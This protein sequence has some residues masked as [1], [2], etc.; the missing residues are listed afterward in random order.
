MT[1]DLTVLAWVA[2]LTA[3]M[4]VPYIL[5]R[6]QASGL[7]AAV[8]YAADKDPLPDW[9]ERAKKAHL[10]AIENLA[11]F[12]AVVIAAHLT[13]QAGAGTAFWSVV[14]LLARIVHYP[15]YISGLPYIRT[16]SFAVA[17]LAI[18]AIFLQVVF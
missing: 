13:Q 10:N 12:A 3:L 8:T 18:M 11:P 7:M 17:W 4:W 5:A 6:I 9:A 1:T 15:G 2:G 14:Y 16:L